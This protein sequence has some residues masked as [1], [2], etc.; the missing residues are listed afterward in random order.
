VSEN[1]TSFVELATSDAT[2][3]I[4]I[5]LT[6]ITE[7]PIEKSRGFR[8]IFYDYY[9]LLSILLGGLA[10]K[11][12]QIFFNSLPRSINV[13]TIFKYASTKVICLLGYYTFLF[14]LKPF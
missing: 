6:E 8:G 13:G 9:N 10:V 14:R 5:I 7:A 3:L 1:S 2:A 12:F 11:I 4:P